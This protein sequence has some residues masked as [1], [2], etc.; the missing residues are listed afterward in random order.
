MVGVTACD[1]HTYYSRNLLLEN[2]YSGKKIKLNFTAQSMYVPGEFSSS[3]PV[4]ALFYFR[5]SLF[6]FQCR[7]LNASFYSVLDASWTSFKAQVRSTV[8][9][10][11]PALFLL[12]Q[13]QSVPV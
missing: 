13:V 6:L 11:V 4:P 3:V 1:L 10:S 7:F 9:F 5:F 12:H 2:F 8:P